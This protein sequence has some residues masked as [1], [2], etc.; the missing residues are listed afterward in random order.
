M[1]PSAPLSSSQR[2]QLGLIT[3][4]AITLFVVVRLLPIGTNLGH[5]D[6]RVVGGNAIE[7][8][9]PARPAFIPVVN[10]R[11]PVQLTLEPEGAPTSGMPVRFTLRMRTISGKPV[12]PRDLAVSHTELLHLLVVDPSLGDYQHIHPKPAGEAGAWEFEMTPQ[13]AGLYRVFADFVP[14]AT[15]L[16]LYAHADFTVPG[17]PGARIEPGA[18]TLIDGYRYE[19]TLR[20]GELRAGRTAELDLGISA[21][22][23]GVVPLEPVMGAYAHVV[24]FDL[25]RN[26][27]AHLHPLA[28]DPLAP[29]DANR[30]RLE[31]QVTIPKAG[32]YIVWGQVNMG[33]GDR[34]APFSLDV[35]P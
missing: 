11:S 3:L 16:G 17:E 23:G 19:F 15:G 4:G 30:P 25:D 22:D 7:M 27:F 13:R 29:P 18:A 5:G 1:S 14:I 10:V 2:R 28:A 24:A 31:F 9:D 32:R 26:G 35:A 33:G 20:G 8:C 34:F 21:P 12:G 6:F